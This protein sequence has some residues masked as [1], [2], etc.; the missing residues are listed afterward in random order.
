MPARRVRLP[1]GLHLPVAG[2]G[3]PTQLWRPGLNGS[4][5]QLRDRPSIGAYRRRETVPITG[6]TGQAT[7]SAGGAATVTTGPQGLGTIWYPQAC[8]VS[9]SVG[10]TDPATVT[11][12]LGP[13]AVLTLVVGQSYAGG[14]DTVGLSS[15]PLAPGQFLTAVWAGGTSGAKASLIVY[16]EQS[17]LT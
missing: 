16:G 13:Q 8:T 7:F 11:I 2:R 3:I 6:A 17:V 4:G 14:G 9:T 5:M 12:Y 10:A 1:V 15:P